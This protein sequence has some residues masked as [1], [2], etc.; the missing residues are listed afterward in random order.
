MG[1]WNNGNLVPWWQEIIQSEVSK[2]VKKGET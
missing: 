1:G 2:R